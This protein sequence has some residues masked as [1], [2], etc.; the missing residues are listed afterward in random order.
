MGGGERV[1]EEKRTR[2]QAEANAFARGDKRSCTRTQTR[3]RYT[4]HLNGT[5]YVQAFIWKPCT[6]GQ[7]LK[8]RGWGG[9]YIIYINHIGAVARGVK[10]PLNE[11]LCVVCLFLTPFSG[12]ACGIYATNN[13]EACTYIAEDCKVAIAVVEDQKQLDKFLKVHY[14][15]LHNMSDVYACSLVPRLSLYTCIN[16][17]LPLHPMEQ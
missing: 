2:S 12:L 13:A 1:C 11:T 8:N 6:G 7:K 9:T 4:L 14:K 10:C 15:Y 5:V 16:Y 3:V 17:I